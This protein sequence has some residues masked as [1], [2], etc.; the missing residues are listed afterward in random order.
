[1]SITTKIELTDDELLALVGLPERFQS[2]IDVA[3]QRKALG[4]E[5]ADLTEKQIALIHSIITFATK[6]GRLRFC[7]KPLRHCEVCNQRAG[8]A[9]YK[10]G[11][12]KGQENINKPLSFGGIDLS[13]DFVSW[14]GHASLGCCYECWDAIKPALVPR[15][16]EIQAEIPQVITGTEPRWKWHAN[17]EC[18]KCGWQGHDGE[19]T[20]RPAMMGGGTY[21]A[22][23]P[24]CGTETAWFGPDNVPR[25]DGFTLTE[26]T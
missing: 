26:A 10:S 16:L 8:Y 3:K 9:R 5:I 23:C 17:R 14:V 1:M 6:Q 2:A 20:R 11:R 4:A 18:K 12:N 22:G 21:P 13:D 25:R 15:L 7:R 24:K 19:M